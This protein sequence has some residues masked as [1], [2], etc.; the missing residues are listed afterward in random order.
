MKSLVQS[1]FG[2]IE[3][4]LVNTD[5]QLDLLVDIIFIFLP[6]GGILLFISW[7]FIQTGFSNKKAPPRPKWVKL[8]ALFGVIYAVLLFVFEL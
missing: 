2:N 1:L 7:N 4:F 8:Y 3:N 6:M 5:I